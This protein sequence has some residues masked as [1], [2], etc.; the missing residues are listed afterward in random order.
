M[1]T[2]FQRIEISTGLPNYIRPAFPQHTATSPV[3]LKELLPN[4]LKNI[5]NSDLEG[6]KNIEV[7]DMLPACL[8][9]TAQCRALIV[10][11]GLSQAIGTWVPFHFW[12]ADS[13]LD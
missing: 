3:L 7:V 1:L 12:T 6:D 13:L 2:F 11:N 10:C 4:N 9:T 8:S 5:F